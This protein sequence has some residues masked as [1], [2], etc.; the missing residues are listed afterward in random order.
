MFPIIDCSSDCIII[1]SKSVSSRRLFER[2]RRRWTNRTK[3]GMAWYLHAK[4]RMFLR[5]LPF[6]WIIDAEKYRRKIV[7]ITWK[8]SSLLDSMLLVWFLPAHGPPLPVVSFAIKE[9][10]S[11][12]A[13]QFRAW[14]PSKRTEKKNAPS[15]K[16][17]LKS[18]YNSKRKSMRFMFITYKPTL[19]CFAVNSENW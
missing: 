12:H 4:R 6:Y 10:L 11:E 8:V 3:V 17:Q 7:Y 5:K 9:N 18:L 19:R 2:G 15:G 1:K 14:T 13:F 16:K